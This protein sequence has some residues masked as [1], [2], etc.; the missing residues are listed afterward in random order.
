M[1]LKTSETFIFAA[2]YSVYT[3]YFFPPPPGQLLHPPFGSVGLNV[4]ENG[5]KTHSRTTATT[6]NA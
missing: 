6:A 5:Q 3:N 1:H 4:R 2:I